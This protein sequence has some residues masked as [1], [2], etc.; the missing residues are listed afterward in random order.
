M[1]DMKYAKYVNPIRL[2][3]EHPI[4]PSHHGTTAEPVLRFDKKVF[5]EI[6][7]WF[8]IFHFYGAGSSSGV[9][10]KEPLIVNCQKVPNTGGGHVHQ[11]DEFFIFMGT[12]PQD[13]MDLGGELEMWLGEGDQAEKYIINKPTAMFSPGGVAH[14]PQYFNRVDRTIIQIVILLAPEWFT[15]RRISLPPNFSEEKFGQEQMGKGQYAK[16]VNPLRMAAE[17]KNPN[18][19]GKVAEPGQRFDKKC[20]PEA[21]RWIQIVHVKAPGG[22]MGIPLKETAVFE[23]KSLPA[24]GFGHTHPFDEMF[25]FLGTD[26]CDTLDLGGEAEFWLGEGDGAEKFTINKATGV[27]VPAG[28]AHNPLYFKKVK[29]PFMVVVFAAAGDYSV[30]RI[31]K[32]PA[33]FSRETR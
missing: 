30:S 11:G 33:A 23:G 27:F 7:H 26:P 4:V 16:Y 1:T 24:E 21:N 5:P 6:T 9:P 32:L 19:L 15:A 20:Y 8:E 28:L 22:G 14:N 13:P 25:L 31:T 18:N 3:P 12:N 29:N 10:S 2:A 17:N